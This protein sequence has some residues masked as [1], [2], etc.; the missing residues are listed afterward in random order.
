LRLL[1]EARKATEAVIDMLFKQLDRKTDRKPRC[2]RDK[3]RNRFLGFIKKKR[4]KKAEIRKEKRF[5]LSEIAS[6]L[7][8]IDRMIHT[9]AS[10]LDLGSH[11][12]KKLLV[13]SEVYRQ[14]QEMYDADSHRIDD[15]IVNLTKAHVRQIIRGKA[16]K[17]T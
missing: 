17:K 16:G 10:L 5:R 13:T 14:Q 12:Y 6:N 1:N 3:E 11:L 7:R 9:G 8:A 15:R 4:S 2:N